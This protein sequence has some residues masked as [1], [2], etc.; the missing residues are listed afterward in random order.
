[1]PAASADSGPDHRPTDRDDQLPLRPDHRPTT[2][3]LDE[4]IRRRLDGGDDDRGLVLDRTALSPVVHPSEP[5]GRGPAIER[6]LDRLG[7]AFEG[8]RPPPLYVHGPKG[9]GKTAVVRAVVDRLSVRTRRHDGTV[10]TAT[11]H[12]RPGTLAF[13]LVDARRADSE[14]G[15]YRTVLDALVDEPVPSQGVGTDRLQSRL[16]DRIDALDGAVVV[17]DHV[18]EPGTHTAAEVADLL[19]AAGPTVVPVAVGRTHPDAVQ[20]AP[21]RTLEITPQGRHAV[22]DVLATR[23]AAGLT[24]DALPY[25]A[26]RQL[27]AWADGDI[28]GALAALFGAVVAAEHRGAR[29]RLSDADLERGRAAVPDDAVAL[30]Q[31]LALDT[32]RR[33]VLRA[34]VA[35]DDDGRSSVGGAASAVARTDG[36]DLSAA[37]VERIVYEL[38]E[39]GFVRRVRRERVEGAGR[40]PSRVD[41]L[42]PT[43]PFLEL[44]DRAQ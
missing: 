33:G 9:A 25:D 38:A 28:H 29:R 12:G 36:V 39:A 21:A 16:A 11:R 14:F 34:L 7:P 15:L 13:V 5:T 30:G 40:P 19:A 1:M 42:V 23:A 31:A 43:V 4:R 8:A 18:G 10:P 17:V 44:T 22:A 32:A 20:W 3:D 37:T 6:F 26:A 27:A 41:P 2:L 24:R 35:L